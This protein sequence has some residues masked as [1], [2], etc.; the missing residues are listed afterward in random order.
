MSKETDSASRRDFVGA[1]C[2]VGVAA[3]GGMA[4]AVGAGFLYPVKRRETK[5]QF[6]CLENEVPQG[7][8]REI[9]GPTGRTVLLM[10]GKGGEFLA[11]ST[12]CSHLGCNVFFRPERN[13]FDCPCH[14]GTFDG[15]G[16]PLSGPA[17][18][19]LDR[20]ATE[21]R[22]GKIFVQFA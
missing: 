7:A 14:N 16:N 20:Y 1:L 15:E 22:D 6:V 8:T 21:V 3:M 5:P 13:E 18:R 19:P 12:I 4:A 2:G 9:V 17:E 10:R 11:L